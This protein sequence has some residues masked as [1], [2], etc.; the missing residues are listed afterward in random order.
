[1]LSEAEIKS[2]LKEIKPF[3]SDKFHVKSIGYFGSFSNGNQTK[4]SDLDLLVEFSEPIGWEFFTLESFLEQYFG[5]RI[6]LVTH[7][8]LKPTM[9][10]T[11]IKQVKYI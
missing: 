10:D 8:A 11:I 2:K 4:S 3:L 1:M 6:D 7:N 9:S 5:L